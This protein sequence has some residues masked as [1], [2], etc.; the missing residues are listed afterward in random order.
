M[1]LLLQKSKC[2]NHRCGQYHSYVGVK[3]VEEVSATETDEG[4]ETVYQL[5]EGVDE[6]AEADDGE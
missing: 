1:R 2:D 5:D 3:P 4:Y 6:G